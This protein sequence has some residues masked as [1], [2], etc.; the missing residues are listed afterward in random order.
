MLHKKNTLSKNILALFDDKNPLI[1]IVTL[2]L[3]SQIEKLLENAKVSIIVSAIAGGVFWLYY[4]RKNEERLKKISYT[5]E[6]PLPPEPSEGL[7]LMLSPYFDRANPDK[8]T[9]DSQIDNIIQKEL[10]QLT[11]EEFQEINLFTSN[12]R[13]QIKAIEYHREDQNQT[14]KNVW[15]I[16]T[17]SDQTGEGSE[18][19]ALLLEKYIKFKYGETIKIHSQGL[20]VKDLDWPSLCQKVEQIFRDSK[21]KDEAIIADITGGTKMMSVALSIACISPKR[22]LQYMDAKRDWQGN[23]LQKGEI[24]PMLIEIDPIIQGNS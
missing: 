3:T 11:L 9:V 13:P 12:L 1:W 2:A 23:P 24:K 10:E 15:L 16:S 8:I 7:I 19:T 20:T 14:L 4:H 18:K 6:S 21:Y 5:V 22:R 17:F